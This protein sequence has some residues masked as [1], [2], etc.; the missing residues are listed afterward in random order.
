MKSVED[1]LHVGDEVRAKVQ[2]T[3]DG[4][5]S[6]SIRALEEDEAPAKEAEEQRMLSKEIEKYSD[7]GEASTSLGDLLKGIK[8]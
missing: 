1:V 3:K 5:V 8:L 6:L 7:K 4:K 2:N